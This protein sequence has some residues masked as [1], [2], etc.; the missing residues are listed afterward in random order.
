M[1]AGVL[2]A[3][4]ERVGEGVSQEAHSGVLYLVDVAPH[5]RG[6]KGR[7][8]PGRGP[9]LVRGHGVLPWR[10]PLRGDQVWRNVTQRGRVLLQADLDR[11]FVSS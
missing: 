1:I 2:E 4:K 8:R 10:R 6:G 3:E 7:P 5:Q 9:A 11:R